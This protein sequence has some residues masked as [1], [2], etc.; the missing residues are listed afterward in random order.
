MSFRSVGGWR[1]SEG[2][3]GWRRL[4]GPVS[5]RHRARALS[6]LTRGPYSVRPWSA[7]EERSLFLKLPDG[8]RTH[9]PPPQRTGTRLWKEVANSARAEA[10]RKEAANS[11]QAA[12]AP[13]EIANSA[14]AAAAPKRGLQTQR[15]LR[16]RRGGWGISHRRLGSNRD[17]GPSSSSRD[18]RSMVRASARTKPVRGAG[19]RY[20]THLAGADH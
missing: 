16:R 10:A 6:T 3:G 14:Q 11:A 19:E 13:K 5:L 17:V 15:S 12:A 7:A 8:H 4:V 9:H 20:P 1:S 2:V 18:G